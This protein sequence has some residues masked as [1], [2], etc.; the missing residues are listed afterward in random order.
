M[1]QA[2]ASSTSS[3]E[4]VPAQGPNAH[5]GPL[6]PG[7][8]LT[9]SDRPGIAQ[10]VPERD[11][12]ALPWLRMLLVSAVLVLLFT[13]LWEWHARS[14]GFEVGDLGDEASAWAQQW[15]RLDS[16]NPPVVI[17][18][19][20]R[21]LFGTDLDRFQQLTGMRPVQL[22]LA[23][24]NG[25]PILEAVANDSSFH[26]L[27]IVGIA[28]QSYFRE[29]IGL[30][31]KA[32]AAGKWE[33]PSARI[34]FPLFRALRRHLAMLDDDMSFSTMVTRLDQY[35][36]KGAPSPYDDVW[37][38]AVAHDDRQMFAWPEFD[39]NAYLRDHAIHFWMWR[40]DN[41][42]PTPADIA[43][44]QARTKAAVAAIRARGGDVVFVR[45]PSSAQIRALE[46][47]YLPREK[48]WE[49]LLQAANV[50][51]IHADEMPALRGIRF[52][53]QSHVSRACSTVFTDAYVRALSK[54]TPRLHLISSTELTAADC[55]E[56]SL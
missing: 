24:T 20:S 48:G 49:P 27:V 16:E 12:P 46:D 35:W 21:I 18:G 19:D 17:V 54:L 5:H 34:S 31:G 26:G 44:T 37:K 40:F 22:A 3:S 10:P 1:G 32:L 33:S 39:R 2:M 15:R 36:R 38:T 50:K 7:L 41:F 51:G 14:L 43:M 13:G 28:D 53:E 9:A 6:A 30:G 8:R 29:A 45:P 23:G 47:H 56:S 11:V 4:P 25:R 52:A 55:A 42:R